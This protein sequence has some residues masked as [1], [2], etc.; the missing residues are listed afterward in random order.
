MQIAAPADGT[1]VEIKCAVGRSVGTGQ[2]LAVFRPD[3]QEIA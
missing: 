2:V 1:V 3:S